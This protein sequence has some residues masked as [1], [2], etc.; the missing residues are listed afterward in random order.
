MDMNYT[1]IPK[2]N[3]WI[4]SG[5]TKPTIECPYCGGGLLG[6]SAPHGVRADGTVYN[7]VVCKHPG[8]NFHYHIK[9][10]GWHGGIVP[11]R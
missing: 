11:H 1:T 4:F 10:E 6:D 3:W 9:L 8:C 2:I 5:E 7:S